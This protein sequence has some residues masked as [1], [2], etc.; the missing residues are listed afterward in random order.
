MARG[1]HDG[2]LLGN[3]EVHAELG[4]R[5]GGGHTGVAGTND[6]QLALAGLYDVGLSDLG[7]GAEPVL[8]AALRGLGQSLL[9]SCGEGETARGGNG[10]GRS[11]T[12][13]EKRTAGHFHG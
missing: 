12:G 3:N 9:R 10:S 11:G 2:A 6:E 5:G 13:G 4:S 7:G 8:G 1:T